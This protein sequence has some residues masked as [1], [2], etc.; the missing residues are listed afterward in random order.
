MVGIELLTILM[1]DHQQVV[2][3]EANDIQLKLIS[4]PYECDKLT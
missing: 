1:T 3:A 4:L 2:S